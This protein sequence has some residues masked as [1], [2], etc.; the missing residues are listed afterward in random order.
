M[1]KESNNF[2]HKSRK[3]ILM[4]L[5]RRRNLC[6]LS[7]PCYL[8]SEANNKTVCEKICYDNKVMMQPSGEQHNKGLG[9][10]VPKRTRKIILVLAAPNRWKRPQKQIAARNAR[11]SDFYCCISGDQRQMQAVTQMLVPFDASS[12]SFRL[13]ISF[14]PQRNARDGSRDT[15][16][17]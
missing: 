13:S 6:A 5:S 7:A 1:A 14:A 12:V 10:A 3:P 17:L 16:K 4:N 2:R 11:A 15:E 8:I 9:M